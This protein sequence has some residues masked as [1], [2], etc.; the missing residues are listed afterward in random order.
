MY[1]TNNVAELKDY[2]W[3][4][5]DF[6]DV[7]QGKVVKEN[8]RVRDE[9]PETR[10]YV[11]EKKRRNR[12]RGGYTLQFEF[13]IAP[14]AGSRIKVIHKIPFTMHDLGRKKAKS[15]EETITKYKNGEINEVDITAVKRVTLVGMLAILAGFFSTVMSIALGIWKDPTP[16]RLKKTT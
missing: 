5:A 6:L 4:R 8:E 15:H 9:D 2:T 11:N 16:K 13:Q 1:T 14:E 12:R 3:Q 7:Y 10:N